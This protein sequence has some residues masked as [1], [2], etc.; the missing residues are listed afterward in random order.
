MQAGRPAEREEL[1]GPPRPAAVRFLRES[2][3]GCGYNIRTM[4]TLTIGFNPAVDRVLECRDF[5]LGGH[6]KARQIARLAAGKAANVSRALAQLA[7]DSIA[8]GFVGSGE[9]EFFHEQLMSAGPGRILCRF[10][11]V[12]GRTRENISILDPKGNAETHIRDQGFTVSVQ[13]ADLLAKKIDHELKPGD[14]AIFSG[15]LCGGIGDTFFSDLLDRCITAQARVVVDSSGPPLRIAAGKKIW[16]L[17]PN[18]EE[19]RHL[20]GE[21]VPNAASAVR[22]AAVGL[23]AHAEQVLV[24]RGPLGAV[25][26]TRNGNYC[27]RLTSKQPPVRTVGC[28]D[29]LLA[30]YV[31]EIGAGREE[32][33]ALAMAVAVATARALSTR[34]DEFDRDLVNGA[35]GSIEIEKI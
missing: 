4:A 32:S 31:S 17:K 7:T 3:G 22:D 1:S 25:L 9:L 5:H 20:V 28:G 11:E 23:L 18:I 10:V 30:G 15:S 8:T 24:T 27:A 21:D 14:V 12:I 33:R 34:M 26:L 19:L 13:E 16:L 35:L 2:G 29:H 6:Q